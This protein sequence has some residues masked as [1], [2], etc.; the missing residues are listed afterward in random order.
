MKVQIYKVGG[1]FRYMSTFYTW[2]SMG[3]LT[4]DEN[5]ISYKSSFMNFGGK[6]NCRLDELSE[7]GQS[8][9]I[10][11]LVFPTKC[12]VMQP[13]GKKAFKFNFWSENDKN[14]FLAFCKENNIKTP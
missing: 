8:K 13:K 14:D 12:L 10:N 11:Y 5:T 6:F 1:F 2:G 9:Y 3:D 4:Y 7:I